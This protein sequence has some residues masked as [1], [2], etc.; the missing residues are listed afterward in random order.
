[1]P[2]FYLGNEK[3]T[4]HIHLFFGDCIKSQGRKMFI[5]RGATLICKDCKV[6]IFLFYSLRI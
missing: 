3:G 6:N 2:E 5:I 1:M 4:I